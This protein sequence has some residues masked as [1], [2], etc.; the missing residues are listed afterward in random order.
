MPTDQSRVKII[1]GSSD[2]PADVDSKGTKKALVVAMVDSDG[3]QMDDIDVNVIIDSGFYIPKSD[4][5][6]VEYPTDKREIYT[7]TLASVQTAVVTLEYGDVEKDK[8]ISGTV[9]RS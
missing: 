2:S 5:F 9:A 4:A 3:N 1:G 7:Y 8:L 6:T